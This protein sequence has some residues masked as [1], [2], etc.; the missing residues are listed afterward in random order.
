MLRLAHRGCSSR[1]LSSWLQ[2]PQCQAWTRTLATHT[3][4]ST[5]DASCSDDFGPLTDIEKIMVNSVKA[6]G[7]FSFATYM[8]LCLSHP[9]HGYYM[10]PQHAVFGTRG[11]FTTSPEISQVFGEL[12]AVW[13]LERWMNLAPS[14][15]FRVV[16]LGPGRGT[17]MDDMLRVFRQ[18]PAARAKLT[19]VHLVETSPAMRTL[20][21]SKLK[22][23]V[24][25]GSPG[26]VWHDALD[27]VPRSPNTYT[28]LVAHEF[29]DALPVHL[30]EKTSHGWHEVLI[31]LSK[32]QSVRYTIPS[33]QSTGS[34]LRS[35]SPDGASKPQVVSSRWTPVLSPTPTATSTLL[36]NVSPRF[37]KLPVGSRIEVSGA[38]VKTVRSIAEL[39][40]HD[41]VGG[42]A[43]VID[44]GAEH[45]VGNSLRAFKEHKIVDIF[46]RPGEC[47]ITA[48]VD[49][50]LL[51]E[52]FGHN[53]T[54]LGT[55]CQ[56][57]FLK[58]LGV[59]LRAAS[60]IRAAPTTERKKAI[61]DGVNRLVDPLG[62]GGQYAVLGMTSEKKGGPPHQGVWPFVDDSN[63]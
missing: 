6:T 35:A 12:V 37:S 16:E 42:C 34:V 14:Q 26:L 63:A 49:F 60:L 54:P 8:Q 36:G 7:P 46:H 58:R 28:I 1:V 11:D 48:N 24:H 43:L 9:I 38:A 18:F 59:Q 21:E 62:M 33:A 31:A 15:P 57:E 56:G 4:Q 61:E 32:D 3:Q 20:Q 40:T 5:L 23:I 52:S 29:F 55:L 13:M 47:D 50:A 10:N 39:I 17:L 45:A 41:G 2:R 53:V 51:K 27:D 22:H 44:Y 19:N 25:N 30:I